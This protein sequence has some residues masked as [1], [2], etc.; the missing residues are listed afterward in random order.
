MKLWVDEIHTINPKSKNYKVYILFNKFFV[1]FCETNYQ[2]LADE[3][4][5]L[6]K[7]ESIYEEFINQDNN[8]K[9]YFPKDISESNDKI[10]WYLV[11]EIEMLCYCNIDEYRKDYIDILKSLDNI[12]GKD[13]EQEIKGY[14]FRRKKNDEKIIM[15]KINTK[16]FE[17]RKIKFEDMKNKINNEIKKIHGINP[18]SKKYKVYVLIGNCFIEFIEKSNSA[19]KEMMYS[20]LLKEN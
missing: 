20:I 14:I 4:E 19:I 10:I 1:E 6:L 12:K 11:G 5:E 8:M 7:V 16:M 9:K 15:I 18:E 17:E 2:C 13:K 3:Y